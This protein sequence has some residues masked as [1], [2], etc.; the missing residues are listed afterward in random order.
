[1]NIMANPPEPAVKRLLSEAKLPTSDITPEKLRTFFGCDSEGELEGL[2]G[3]ELYGNVGLLRSLVVRP[4]RRSKGFGSALAAHAQSF[5][6]ASGVSSLYL[7]TTTAESFFRRL[8]YERV[9]REVA[10]PEIQRTS[11][12]SGICPVSSTFMVKHLTNNLLLKKD[13][14]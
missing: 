8:G 10:P 2:V 14:G 4:Q 11:Q 13:Q 7:L 6:Q 3:L 12:F 9:P 1:M 5:A